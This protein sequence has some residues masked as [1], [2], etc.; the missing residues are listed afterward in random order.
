MVSG[1]TVGVQLRKLSESLQQGLGGVMGVYNEGTY[2][3]VSENYNSRTTDYA[4]LI[5][6]GLDDSH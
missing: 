4:K 5:Y 3:K 2:K 6:S 1:I